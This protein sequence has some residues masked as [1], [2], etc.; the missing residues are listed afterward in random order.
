MKLIPLLLTVALLAGLPLAAQV[1]SGDLM[2]VTQIREGVRTRRAGSY[3]RTGGNTDTLTKIADGERRT[4]LEV[5]GAGIINRIW[6]TIAPRADK[7]SRNDIIL[8]MYWDG[9]P[10]PSVVSPIGPF[11]GQGWNEAYNFVSAP[12]AA[13]PADGASLVSYFAMP[14]ARGARIEIENQTGHMIE[15]FYFNI[16]YTAMDRLPANTG[17]FHAWFNREVTEAPPTGEN[18]WNALSKENPAPNTTGAGNYLIADIKGHGQFVGVNYYVQSPT[19]MWYGEGDEMIF[20]D[21]ETTPSIVGTGTE[22]YF[23]T[24]WCPREVY[25]HPYFGLAHVTK[26]LAWIGRHHCYRFHLADPIYFERSLRFTIEHGQANVLTLDLATVAYWYQS[27][28]VAVPPIPDKA[29]RK[30]LPPVNL[31]DIHRWRDAWR[32]AMGNDPRLWGNE[33]PA[34][35]P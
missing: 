27:E 14:F 30:L 7:L 1:P 18:E 35:K 26:E 4:L 24:A 19:P 12:L 16:D 21:G 6:F 9:N 15:A 17:R 31:G 25:L 11:F 8:R 34:A 22:D 28:A 29:G 13:A 33:T 3:D 10:E 23:N 5:P 32:K 2:S 20:I